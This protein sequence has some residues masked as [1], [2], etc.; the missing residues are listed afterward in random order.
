MKKFLAFITIAAFASTPVLGQTLGGGEGEQAGRMTS[1]E[2]KAYLKTLVKTADNGDVVISYNQ[3]A[4]FEK[5][6]KL[7]YVPG[8]LITLL[9][10]LDPSLDLDKLDK[11]MGRRTS[12]DGVRYIT[13]ML[14]A[15]DEYLATNNM[16]LR[17]ARYSASALRGRLA[18]GIPYFIIL[19]D[20]DPYAKIADRTKKRPKTG[21]MGAWAKDLR[22]DAVKS[23]R[24]NGTF[25]NYGIV[26]GFNKETGEYLV[27]SDGKEMWMAEPEI[28]AM[29]VSLHEPRI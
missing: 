23:F 2:R 27:Y 1:A 16:R 7:S 24:K 8:Y 18:D 29:S 13:D 11:F 5:A 22:K 20:G 21:N 19:Y 26:M 9:L 15:A 10:H 28:K 12:K 17:A 4:S 6:A 25:C 14:F 3:K